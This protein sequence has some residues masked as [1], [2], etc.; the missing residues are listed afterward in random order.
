[1]LRLPRNLHLTLH[2]TLL[3]RCACHAI[4]T[5][6]KVDLAKVLRLPRNLHPTLPKCCA[7]HAIQSLRN[8]CVAVP[9]GPAPS[10]LRDRSEHAPNPLRPDAA[11]RLAFASPDTPIRAQGHAFCDVL[12]F[13]NADSRTGPRRH[14]LYD[15]LFPCYTRAQSFSRAYSFSCILSQRASFQLVAVTRKFLLNF[16]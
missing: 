4:Q 12:I 10:P 8:L 6:R 2:L 14:A 5:L 11:D 15:F 1:M 9:R 16:L 7:C 13:G 3:K